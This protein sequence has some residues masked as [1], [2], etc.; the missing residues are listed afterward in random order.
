M[1]ATEIR[2]WNIEE[3]QEQ[4]DDAYR[5]L[6]ALRRD[7][8]SGRLADTNQL[9]AVKRDIARMKTILRERELGAELVE[10]EAEG[11]EA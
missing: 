2:N 10:V 9:K 1:Q 4:L 3:L 5:Q 6:F 11:G 7:Q 8:A